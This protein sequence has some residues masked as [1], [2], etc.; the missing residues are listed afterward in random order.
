MNPESSTSRRA[1]LRRLAGEW[2]EG[3]PSYGERI[4]YL[5][6]RSLLPM[7]RLEVSVCALFLGV[8][9]L[10]LLTV[11]HPLT[12]WVI[13][14][15]VAAGAVA[16]FWA[17][18]WRIG[19]VPTSRGAAIFFASS[20]IAIYAAS[21]A[22]KESVA[23]IAS[24]AMIA[25]FGALILATR[26]FLVNAALVLAAIVASTVAVIP[27][28]GWTVAVLGAAILVGATI[29]VPAMMQFGMTFSWFDTAEAGTDP[30]TGARNRRGLTT[31]W[32]TWAMRRTPSAAHVGVIVLDLDR[33]K[34]INDAHGHHAGDETLVRVARLLRAEG[35]AVDAIV[36]R[37]GGDEFALL[38]VGHA[39]PTYLDLAERVR[40]GVRA[41][42]A[43]DGVAIT[44]SIG[45]AATD[46]PTPERELL[47]GLLTLADAAMYRAKRTGDAVVAS[48]DTTAH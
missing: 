46:A 5:R 11:V 26:A 35:A 13:I 36:A 32:A 21:S 25:T 43:V 41:L 47:D 38:I 30:L 6:N 44:A 34:A 37:L 12:P 24:L 27:A 45:V 19:D 42:P 10:V 4:A 15:L 39:M 28:Q 20:I 2:W 29:G 14:R 1:D 33:F 9:S 7:V 40:E 48:P 18:R 22:Q 8:L 17:I 16:L 23:F 3:G 31:M